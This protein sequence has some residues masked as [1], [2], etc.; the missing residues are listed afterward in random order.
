MYKGEMPLFRAL[1]KRLDALRAWLDAPPCVAVVLDSESQRSLLAWWSQGLGKPFLE[2]V[3]AHHMT[4]WYNPPE[5][6]EFPIGLRV[7]LKVVGWAADELGQAVVVRSPEVLS[8]NLN[9][10]VT[11][12]V[13]PGTG[14]VYSNKLLTRG[15]AVADGPR[16]H[17]VVKVIR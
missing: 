14:A 16:L 8:H 5:D 11:V 9:P 13:S 3:K 10:H 2:D 4:V 1:R 15:W 6:R 17:G 7:S 12:S